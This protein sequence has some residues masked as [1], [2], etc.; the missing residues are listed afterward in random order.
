MKIEIS[1]KGIH[2]ECIN[3]QKTIELIVNEL[4]MLSKMNEHNEIFPA[5][6]ISIIGQCFTKNKISSKEESKKR[7][8]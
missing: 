7:T 1:E 8:T 2:I 4:I 6:P 3:D 5:N